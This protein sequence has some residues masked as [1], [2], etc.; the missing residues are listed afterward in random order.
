MNDNNEMPEA[1]Q[2]WIELAMCQKRITEEAAKAA[3]IMV[4]LGKLMMEG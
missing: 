3:S 1:Q 4:R 2:L